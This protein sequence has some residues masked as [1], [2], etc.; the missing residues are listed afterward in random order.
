MPTFTNQATLTYNGLSTNSNVVAGELL[1]VLSITKTALDPDYAVGND[2][3]YAVNLRN[4]GTTPITG[5]TLT[6][7]MGAFA[8][9]TTT[10]TPLRYVEGSARYFINGVLQG[11]PT[12]TAGPPMTVTGIEV[13]AGG[14]TMVLY[15][16][17][18][19]EFA[20]PS[21]GS[22]ITN[23]A[24]VSGAATADISDTE[25]VVVANDPNLTISKGIS[26]DPVA[27]NDVLTYTFTVFNNGNR[28][29]ETGDNASVT[30][31]F[32]P[33]L[34]DLTVTFNGN[35]WTEGTNYTYDPA[36]GVFAT[37][38]GQITVPAAASTQDPTTG[39][40]T[41]TPGVSTLVVSGTV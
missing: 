23:T 31:T 15:R 5:L 8:F 18:P 14:N 12:V 9:D 35:T 22:T 38:P 29:A 21:V 33:R 26:P 36:T 25:D 3:T 16:T 19:T 1:E 30:D 40:F 11:E 34:R 39:A 28:A 37:V 17:V 4:T 6:D 7:D 13:P 41:I 2:I 20:D 24:T 27:S 32:D 10:V